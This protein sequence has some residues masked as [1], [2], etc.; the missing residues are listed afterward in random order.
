MD[1]DQLNNDMNEI[2][3]RI[4]KKEAEIEKAI[5]EKKSDDYI[6]SLNNALAALQQEKNILLQRESQGNLFKLYTTNLI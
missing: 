4:S 1:K 2:K 6:A 5:A 3:N